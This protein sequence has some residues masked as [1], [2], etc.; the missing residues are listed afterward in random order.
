[1]NDGRIA[2]PPLEA[3]EQGVREVLAEILRVDPAEI[4]PGASLA[5]D[6]NVD[7]L[8]F[9]SLITGLERSFNVTIPDSQAARLRTVAQ[10]T[11]AVRGLVSPAARGAA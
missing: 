11:E 9:M 3:I 8:D 10:V 2:T 4:R 1:M 5:D 7:S 6:L